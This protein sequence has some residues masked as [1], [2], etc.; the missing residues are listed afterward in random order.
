MRRREFIGSAVAGG[1]V[2]SGISPDVNAVEVNS[3]YEEYKR[4]RCNYEKQMLLAAIIRISHKHDKYLT[5]WKL[6]DNQYY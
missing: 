1:L 6:S 3:D 2:V 5:G 4:W